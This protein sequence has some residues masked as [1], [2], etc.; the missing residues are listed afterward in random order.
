MYCIDNHSIVDIQS[1]LSLSTVFLGI[2]RPYGEC[3]QHDIPIDLICSLKTVG[4]R[5]EFRL[6]FTQT[7]IPERESVTFLNNSIVPRNDTIKSPTAKLSDFLS[8]T[9]EAEYQ[10][11]FNQYLFLAIATETR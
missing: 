4:H 9:P 8:R 10:Q 2:N 5:I 6:K 1:H 11:F 7:I 3:K